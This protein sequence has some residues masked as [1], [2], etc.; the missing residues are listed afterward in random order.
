MSN[1]PLEERI[2]RAHLQLMKHPTWCAFAGLYLMGSWKVVD[3]PI[4][5]N[6]DV[7]GN[8]QFGREYCSKLND[9]ELKFAI[10]HETL[11]FALEHLLVWERLFK[12]DPDTAGIAADFVVNGRI[13]D[14]DPDGREVAI[15]KDAKGVLQWYYDPKYTGW[16]VK[17]VYD[18][19]RKNGRPQGGKGGGFDK[20][21]TAGD[22]DAQGR[23]LTPEE[24]QVLQHAIQTAVR[25]GAFLAGK[26][27]GNAD[28][29]LG[30]LLEPKV[31]WKEQ[32]MDFVQDVSQGDDEA[33]WRKVNR[34]F[35]GQDIYLPSMISETIGELVITADTSY[36]THY[37]FPIFMSE[38]AH[39]CKIA[40]PAAV[41]LIYWDD[42]VQVVER[43]MPDEYDDMRN[44]TKPSGGGGTQIATVADYVYENF[45]DT[46]VACIN[47]SDGEIP[48]SWTG[49]HGWGMPT[50]WCLTTKAQAPVGKTIFIDERD[51]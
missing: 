20:H 37:V 45:R 38:I 51:L 5:A 29:A 11:H 35:V 36:S 40:K 7:R 46:A 22:G 9:K 43:Y 30:D 3:D 34:R 6:V 1:R 42:G 8:R 24:K 26:G 2:K 18:D 48:G 13:V 32:T 47:L 23:P 15:L 25:N 41:N 17:Q 14:S 10:I 31:D 16:S 28:R 4:T 39:I 50:L 12:E 21:F 49:K 44:S 19:L 33:S 27:K